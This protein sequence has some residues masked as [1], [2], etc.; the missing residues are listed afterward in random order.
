MTAAPVSE[1]KTADIVKAD[2]TADD[3]GETAR[4]AAPDTERKMV[5]EEEK[6]AEGEELAQQKAARSAPG[7][8]SVIQDDEDMDNVDQAPAK[9]DDVPPA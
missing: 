7:E 9:V 8:A 2:Q 5:D 6:L 3:G 1:A 4:S